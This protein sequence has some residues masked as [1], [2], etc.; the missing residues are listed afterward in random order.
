MLQTMKKSSL[1]LVLFAIASTALV[2]ITYALT[3][4]QITYQQQQQLLSVLNQVVPTKQHDNELF[5]ACTLISNV[6][7]LGTEE[8]MPVYLA[9]LN[10]KHSGA[11]IEAIAPDG[12]SGAIKVIVGVDANSIVT[13][14]RVLSHQETPG[15]GD[16]I[17]TRI[18]RWV[19]GFLGKSVDSADDSSWAVQKDGGQFDQFTGAT[20][21]PRAVVK[22]VKKAVWFYKT[23]QDELQTLPLNCK[24]N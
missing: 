17:D 7:A 19:D 12:Y 13:G 23:H 18:T 5:K 21:T 4:D 14:V 8:A 24:A 9:S 3:K 15:L 6:D 10:G 16:K 11:A 22:A 20:I 1:V 2:T